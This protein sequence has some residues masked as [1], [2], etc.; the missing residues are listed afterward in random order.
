MNLIQT[1]TGFFGNHEEPEEDQDFDDLSELL[2]KYNNANDIIDTEKTNKNWVDE[3]CNNVD[4]MTLEPYTNESLQNNDLIVIK[5]LMSNNKFKTGSCELKSNILEQLTVDRKDI[6]DRKSEMVS[7]P[8]NIKC[9]WEKN[10]DKLKNRSESDIDYLL[11]SGMC[12]QP[13]SKFVFKLNDN[14]IITMQSLID[15]LSSR[16]QVWYAVPMFGNKR[17]RIGNVYGIP[18][19]S[20]DH[21][22]IPGSIVYK[23]YTK[24]QI[25]NKIDYKEHNLTPFD[26]LLF[27]ESENND[28]TTEYRKNNISDIMDLNVAQLYRIFDYL[29]LYYRMGELGIKTDNTLPP[30]P[31]KYN[32]IYTKKQPGSDYNEKDIE[33]MIKSKEYLPYWLNPNIKEYW[34]NNKDIKP[35][36]TYFKEH[37]EMSK[38]L[39]NI[40]KKYDI[41][42]E[43]KGNFIYVMSNTQMGMYVRN[44]KYDL[45]QIFLLY[46]KFYNLI[47]IDCSNRNITSIPIYPH[48]QY[49]NC[50]H[51][52]LTSLPINQMLASLDCSHNQL[53]TL[54]EIRYL[55]DLDCS[56]NQLTTLPKLPNLA[57]LN[58]RNNLLKTLP[59][60]PNL[61][62]LNVIN[63]P[64]TDLPDYPKL[65]EMQRYEPTPPAPPSSP[66]NLIRLP[67]PTDNDDF[68]F[69]D[70]LSIPIGRPGYAQRPSEAQRH[71][72][73][74][75]S[76]PSSPTNLIRLP[77]PREARIQHP[78]VSE[79]PER[80]ERPERQRTQPT[81]RPQNIELGN[82][83]E[84]YEFNNTLR[85]CVKKCNSNQIRNPSTQKC[86]KKCDDDKELSD[87]GKCVKKCKP[88]ETRHP[89]TK[90][91]RKSVT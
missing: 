3:N 82:C 71:E 50:S 22:Q 5:R 54:P 53:T 27:D 38:T 70:V 78:A 17:K 91:C 77:G 81:Q 19:V 57:S 25:K 35:D 4:V 86:I 64:I 21:G 6:T 36:F 29:F 34:L 67:S 41:N 72:P 45:E 16:N 20:G 8:V 65:L 13:T 79:R 24:D 12:C 73:S 28:F 59:R 49:L 60:Y 63:N 87:N 75:P 15:L 83:R 7:P 52:Q 32:Y 26:N 10:V 61:V 37:I 51:N 40:I 23:L 90:R 69:L 66:T 30:K 11:K 88:N 85:R 62:V 47:T 89:V 18:S 2:Q 14:T 9:I 42:Y 43:D 74:P 76:P 48:L 80:P 39:P 44:G 56:Y 68:E 55:I 31:N 46:Y 84:G 58:C 33:K 1:I